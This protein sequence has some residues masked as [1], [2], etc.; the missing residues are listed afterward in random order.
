MNYAYFVLMLGLVC[1]YIQ[2]DINEIDHKNLEDI[3]ISSQFE[4]DTE[5]YAIFRKLFSEEE[6]VNDNKKFITISLGCNCTPA[7]YTRKYDV[8]AF[9]FPFDWCLTPYQALY[10]FI[11]TDFSNYFKKGNLVPSS[12][13]YFTNEM[14]KFFKKLGYIKIS[15]NS[16]WVLDKQYGMV[17]NHDFTNNN[18]TTINKNYET[19]YTK[20]KRRVERLY[21]EVNSNKHVYFIRYC[22]ISKS[23]TYKLL[24]LLK[25]K[26][27]KTNFT[28]IVIGNNRKKFS[29]DWKISHV[30]NYYFDGDHEGFWKKLCHDI[31]TGDLQ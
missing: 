26:F 13:L 16:N 25:N 31:T 23:Q 28:L 6:I 19:Q 24:Q 10:D 15:E 2:A 20:Y 27:P 29:Q 22:D 7:W 8:R 12:K 9:A 5:E 3:F 1:C 4:S 11:K 21:S 18:L 30:K 14:Q 17:Y